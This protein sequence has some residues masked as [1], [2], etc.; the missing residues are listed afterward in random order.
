MAQQTFKFGPFAFEAARQQ[1]T[2][3]G[4]TLTIGQRAAAIL[5][6]LLQANGSVVSKDE[7]F[8]AAWPGQIVEESNLS[9]QIAALRKAL[10]QNAAG[11]DWIMTAQRVG[12]RFS[13][14]VGKGIGPS[15]SVD[16][17]PAIAVLPFS[18]S[19]GEPGQDF[20]ADGLTED[21]I[22]DLSNVP[23]FV[24]IAR[25]STLVYKDK[26]TDVRQIAEDLGVGYIV[27][28]N[29]RKSADRV[30]VNVQLV[31]ASSGAHMWAE[32]FDRELADVFALQDE[33]ARRI[34]GA[35]SGKLTGE[36]VRRNRPNSIEAYEL[37]LRCRYMI[38]QSKE[39]NAEAQNFLLH[40]IELEPDYAEAHRRL[41]M[42]YCFQWLHYDGDQALYRPK[43]L[44]AAERAVEL[45]PLDS[46]AYWSL[47]WVQAYE[48]NWALASTNFNKAIR[49]NP[50]D[51]DALA[52]YGDF[53]AMDGKPLEAIETIRQGLR[54][55]PR[56]PGWY[57]WLLGQALVQLGRFEEAVE[58]LN[59]EETYR[60]SSRRVL[61]VALWKLGRKAEAKTEAD[62][63]MASLPSARTSMWAATRP[64]RRP[65]DLEFW[66]TA[67]REAG[68][69]D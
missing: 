36:T 62:L 3:S 45:D 49:I 16:D 9:V 12:Y 33:V 22:T 35:I 4:Q 17:K 26:P 6:T 50:N 63:F 5:G 14:D 27:E 2:R 59:R 39:A 7:L 53:L 10:G 57:F 43:S 46:G 29:V 40:A 65:E 8:A 54:L 24:V 44:A 60:T 64:F 52:L 31:D 67:F 30:R 42:S 28:G 69:P 55:N 47:A 15:A 61:A 32:R 18:N 68:L 21:I 20:F 37:C 51:A 34:V 13:S 58:V 23:N 66:V 41:A 1:L 56:P 11:E 19:S 25:N 38:T 48:R